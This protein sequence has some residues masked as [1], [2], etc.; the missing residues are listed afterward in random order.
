MVPPIPEMAILRLSKE[1]DY[2]LM[3]AIAAHLY[4]VRPA[5]V[6]VQ[7]RALQWNAMGSFSL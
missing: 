6:A 5:L 1:E 4:Q 3:Q 7:A 2:L